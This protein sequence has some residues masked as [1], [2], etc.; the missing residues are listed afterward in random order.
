MKNLITES[1]ITRRTY[2][3]EEIRKLSGDFGDDSDR[4]EKEL[5]DEIK[6]RGQT[7]PAGIKTSGLGCPGS[8]GFLQGVCHSFCSWI[9]TVR[10]LYRG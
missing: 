6:N 8:F 2:W 10:K 5:G 9:S 4:L 7:P 3:V 1:A